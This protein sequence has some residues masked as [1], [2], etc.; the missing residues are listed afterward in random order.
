MLRTCHNFALAFAVC[1]SGASGRQRS[2][3]DEVNGWT[4]DWADEFDGN[5]LDDKSWRVL[6]SS[7]ED[8]TSHMLGACRSAECRAENVF[9]HDGKLVLHSERDIENRSRYYTGAVDTMKTRFWDDSVPYRVCISAKLPGGGSVNQGIWPAHWM[10]PVNG[11]CDPDQ[12]EMDIMEM[13]NGDGTVWATYHWM[14]SWPKRACANFDTYHETSFTAIPVSDYDA[15]FHEFAVER[16]N[17]GM[18]F[19]ID[20]QV[21]N[22]VSEVRDGAILSHQPFFL[23]LNTAIGGPWPGEPRQD[24]SLPV[25]HLIDY[26]RVVRRTGNPAATGSY[27][28]ASL[29]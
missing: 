15:E 11:S 7:D 21:V 25:E 29:Q 23:I 24:T 26:V 4:L 19:A 27:F 8:G 1:V 17:A 13:V 3:C 5:N 14:K 18:V 20:G 2:F 22:A 9:V 6:R 28:L 16:T 10:L 12:G